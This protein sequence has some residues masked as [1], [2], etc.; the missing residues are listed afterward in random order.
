M[1]TC[2]RMK[3][4]LECAEVHCQ[5]SKRITLLVYLCSQV[6]KRSYNYQPKWYLQASSM[7]KVW[8]G[9]TQC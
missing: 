1:A 8:A 2:I 7:E 5:L 3:I 6:A 4:H 9:A